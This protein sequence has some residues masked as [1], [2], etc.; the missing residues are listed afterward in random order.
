MHRHGEGVDHTGQ[1]AEFPGDKASVRCAL[2]TA[3]SAR[4]SASR[5]RAVARNSSASDRA[6]AM[7]RA[8]SSFA[9]R[10]SSDI[11]LRRSDNCSVVRS[12]I[13]REP[14]YRLG[15]SA[16]GALFERLGPFRSLDVDPGRLG[17]RILTNPV[18]LGVRGGQRRL[19]LGEQ[20]GSLLRGGHGSGRPTAL[21]RRSQDQADLQPDPVHGKACVGVRLSQ[22]LVAVGLGN[23][24]QFRHRP[25]RPL[26]LLGRG[27]EFTLGVHTSL[28]Q[29]R[30]GVR[31]RLGDDLLRLATCLGRVV[32]GLV[33]DAGRFRLRFVQPASGILLE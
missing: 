31:A 24:E 29:D 12:R 25:L 14:A 18:G 26:G 16:F 10:R 28:V 22:D 13:S 21:P 23:R 17:L 6:S 20:D 4:A 27:R 15:E 5:L 33:D 9:L 32:G 7:V 30:R 1:I 19:G 3:T 8:A 11:S 2:R